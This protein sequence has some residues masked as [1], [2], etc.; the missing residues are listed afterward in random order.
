MLI[1][2]HINLGKMMLNRNN[3]NI[4]NH[5]LEEKIISQNSL[6]G[7]AMFFDVGKC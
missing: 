3:I 7:L 6:L 1:I 2:Y 4:Y 5:L